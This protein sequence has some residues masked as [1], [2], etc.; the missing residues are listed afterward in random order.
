MAAKPEPET[1]QPHIPPFS[2]PKFLQCATDELCYSIS[3]LCLQF[4]VLGYT[5][6]ALRLLDKV[7]KYEKHGAYHGIVRPLWLLWDL[8]GEWPAGEKERVRE[9]IVS[10]RKRRAEGDRDG[11]ERGGKQAKLELDEQDITEEDVKVYMEELAQVFR[12]GWYWPNRATRGKDE[13]G[14]FEKTLSPE[15]EKQARDAVWEAIDESFEPAYR[16]ETSGSAAMDVSSGLV[17]ALDLSISLGD[18]DDTS[19]ETILQ[20][21]ATRLDANQAIRYLVESRRAWSILKDGALAKTLS[22]D[23]E[24]TENF[25]KE[26]EELVDER[27]KNGRMEIEDL[28]MKEVLNMIDHNTRNG[29]EA[30]NAYFE[31]DDPIPD[32]LFHAPATE[33]QIE[34]AE[35]KLD[36]RLPPDYKE[37]LRISNGLDAAFGGIIFEPPLFPL[38]KARWHTDDE[39]YFTDLRIS[40]PGEFWFNLPRGFDHDDIAGW[41][42]VGKCIEVGAVDIYYVW[43]VP[44]AKVQEVQEHAADI[45]KDGSEHAEDV[46]EV[47]KKSC[48]DFAGS[49]EKWD[50]LEWC[51][52][53]WAAGGSAS[54]TG[55]PSFKAYLR[56][57]AE[58][59]GQSAV[60]VLTDRKFF[61][62]YCQKDAPG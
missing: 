39:E 27:L 60:D 55:Y 21:I 20:R 35:K 13:K 37:L 26:I 52:I 47:L 23:E 59:S 41:P 4:A 38:E 15:E 3:E 34:E 18:A 7:N 12:Q 43:L 62:Y 1:F 28:S 61:G 56:R 46:K 50:A 5:T 51:C 9:E 54:M 17:G 48:E 2:R 6:V 57:V 19:T 25:A 45:L 49:M 16:D 8:L 33:K 31:R 22:L 53:V 24:K 36:T 10:E 32:T 44:P 30:R 29:T 14:P 40:I 42:E 11:E 58:D